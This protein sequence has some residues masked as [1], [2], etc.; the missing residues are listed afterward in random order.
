MVY[1]MTKYLGV[2]VI[3]DGLPSPSQVKDYEKMFNDGI[4]LNVVASGVANKSA[5][6]S[7]VQ[8]YLLIFALILLFYFALLKFLFY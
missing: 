6:Q 3:R 8:V 5:L 1:N 4:Y 2:G 7:Q